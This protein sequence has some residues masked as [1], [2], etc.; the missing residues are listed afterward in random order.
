MSD[1]VPF[2]QVSAQPLLC[3]EFDFRQFLAAV[4]VVKVPNPPPQSLVDVADHIFEWHA[5]QLSAGHA[6]DTALDRS[7]GLLGGLHMGVGAPRPP[8]PGDVDCETEK[9]EAVL[10]GIHD[11]GLLCV[12]GQPQAVQH[13][14]DDRHGTICSLSAEHDQVVGVAHQVRTK[15]CLELVPLP[16]SVQQV[17]VQVGQKWGDD[18]PNAKDNP[19]N[20]R[21]PGVW[22]ADSD[23]LSEWSVEF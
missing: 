2:P 11:V 16:D 12:Q 20:S 10:C 22:I 14:L 3:M 13:L 18:S 7:Q 6:G 15:P 5:G 9:I 19:A 1:L 21:L 4:A 17:Q 23:L 8:T